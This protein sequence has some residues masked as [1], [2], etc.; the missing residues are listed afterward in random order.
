MRSALL[1]GDK[2][3]PEK[4][5]ASEQEEKQKA[6]EEQE[7]QKAAAD[8]DAY[9][10]H[11]HGCWRMMKESFL[12]FQSLFQM[13][14]RR[15]FGRS[16]KN[17]DTHLP[18]QGNNNN[19][20]Q[21]F[22]H[23]RELK[24]AGI[25]FQPSGTSFLT[26]IS[27]E[28]HFFYGYLKLPVLFI[29]D[30]TKPMFLNLVAYEMCPDAPDDYAVTSFLCFLNDLIDHPDDVKELRSKKILYNGLGSDDEVAQIFN[31]IGD[32]LIDFDVYEDVKDDIQKHYDKR[33]NTWIAQ[34]YH[35]HCSSPWTIIAV[36]AAVLIILLTGIQTYFAI[37]CN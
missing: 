17:Q 18:S 16:N 30:S 22:R 12:S 9:T 5:Q 20:W 35:D 10:N 19:K 13:M 31:E 33:M 14:I 4:E 28:S 11:T 6:D 24:A 37:P 8:E 21:S 34:A 15:R 23:I 29:D 2:Q 3:Q 25:H 32:G 7:E 26:D 36:I 27:F 1:G